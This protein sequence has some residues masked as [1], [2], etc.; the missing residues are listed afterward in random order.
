MRQLV[1][2]GTIHPGPSTSQ[3]KLLWAAIGLASTQR[4]SVRVL[5]TTIEACDATA[6]SSS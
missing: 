2:N 1:D 6:L 5:S 3:A 4:A